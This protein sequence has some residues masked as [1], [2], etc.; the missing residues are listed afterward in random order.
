MLLY[1]TENGEYEDLATRLQR[2]LL[3]K[4]KVYVNLTNRCTCA[5][6]FCLRNTK[7]MQKSNSLWLKQEPS[8]QEII[9][10]FSRYNM[11][12]FNEIVFCGFGEP[13]LRLDVLL[14]VARYLK[15][16]NGNIPLRIN[17]N[18]LCELEADKEIAPLF[19]GLI[20][21]VSISLNASNATEYLRLTRNPFGLQSFDAMLAF[22]ASCK[23]YVPYVVLTVVDCIGKTEIAACQA[24]ADK[25]GLTLRVRPFE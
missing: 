6:T 18:G 21:I 22:A 8:A 11:E 23:K 5:C 17:T 25:I 16:H 19:R 9:T 15:Q 14:E 4:T 2:K 24:L 3:H 1:T 20:D 13:T 7:E 10:E 12:L